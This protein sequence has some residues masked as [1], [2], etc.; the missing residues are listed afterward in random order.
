M[1]LKSNGL[2]KTTKSTSTWD[3]SQMFM[4]PTTTKTETTS[5]KSEPTSTTTTI[6]NMSLVPPQKK[7]KEVL[8]FTNMNDLEIKLD[9]IDTAEVIVSPKA[10]AVRPVEVEQGV[11]PPKDE[12]KEEGSF[13]GGSL[14][15][16]L[17]VV[18]SAGDEIVVQVAKPLEA[19]SS[20]QT[21]SQVVASK[22]S[23]KIDD[24]IKKSDNEEEANN[25][26]DDD[27]LIRDLKNSYQDNEFGNLNIFRILKVN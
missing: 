24:L 18:K 9:P 17:K 27:E 26:G 1:L 12:K 10:E 19:S 3:S 6:E 25:N 16:K 22:S 14:K 5:E 15:L 4:N 2:Y 20:I 13:G 11:K 23:E 8:N 21:T 7:P